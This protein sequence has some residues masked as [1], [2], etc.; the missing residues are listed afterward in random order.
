MPSGKLHP[1]L[2][3][4][5]GAGSSRWHCPA[6]IGT[7]TQ[8]QHRPHGKGMDSTLCPTARAVKGAEKTRGAA[9]P[10]EIWGV[11][12]CAGNRAVAQVPQVKPS[13]LRTHPYLPGATQPKASGMVRGKGNT[14]GNNKNKGLSTDLLRGCRGSPGL[15]LS[16]GPGGPIS[17]YLCT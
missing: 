13:A 14:A 6:A 8:P 17:K 5:P 16:L 7:D 3:L 1:L 12:G 4:T 11:G 9:K 2:S 10:D 15:P